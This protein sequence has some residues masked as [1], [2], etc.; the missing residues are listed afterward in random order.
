M[1]RKYSEE[2]RIKAFEMYKNGNS[3]A[4]ICQEFNIASDS[5]IRKWF[6][7]CVQDL[8]LRNCKF[9]QKM[10]KTLGSRFLHENRCAYNP[11]NIRLCPNC[12]KVLSVDNAMA[13]S[14]SCYNKVFRTK[15][16]HP[17]YKGESYRDICY[18]YHE[19]KC[20]IC[21]EVN[22]VDVHHLDENHKNSDAYNLIPLCPT[23][24][25]YWHTKKLKELVEYKVYEYIENCKIIKLKEV[26]DRK[27]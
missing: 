23:H 14:K 9:C 25:K 21:G 26:V 13:C 24:H 8:S 7:G 6:K 15:E 11:L 20:V 3:L 18:R 2:V 22:A 1:N 10:L 19:K 5:T 4:E 27:Q 16:N 12:D 17:T